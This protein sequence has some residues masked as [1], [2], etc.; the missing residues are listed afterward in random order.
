LWPV[1]ALNV[2][3]GQTVK[4]GEVLARLE[5]RDLELAVTQAEQNLA[6][7]QLALAIL[8]APPRPEDVALAQANAR[9]ASNQVY[10]A[11]LGNPTTTVEI[12]RLQLIAAQG[13]LEQTHRSMDSLVE[14][15]K[16]NEKVALESQEKQQIDNARIAALRYDQVQEKPAFGRAAAAL[17]AME[18]AQAQLEKLQ[19]GPSPEDVDIAKLQISQAEAALEI[20]YNNLKNA[21]IVAPFA[22]VI[23]AVNLRVGEPAASAL[24]AVVLVDISQFYLEVLVDEVDVARLVP[25]QRVSVTLDALPNALLAAQVE[26]IAQ[27]S[28]LNAGVVSYQVRVVLD[29]NAEPLRGGMTATAEIVVKEAREVVLVPNWAIRR[30][31]DTGATF[32]G[33]L[34]NGAVVDVPVKLGLRDDTHSEVISGLKEGE[35]VAVDTTRE[36]FNLFGAGN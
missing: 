14:Q 17:A 22:G 8:Q 2:E 27:T 15:G 28:T 26:K 29:K 25:G 36:Q 20:A 23:A 3:L 33:I 7:A 19:N 24:P 32:V 21:R 11:S 6:M 12:A 31:Q 9:V 4:A 10:A 1:V 5:S 16:W 13:A 18:Q 34:Q 35:T 30:D